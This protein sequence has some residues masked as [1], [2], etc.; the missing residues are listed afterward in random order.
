VGCDH[1]VHVE[2]FSASGYPAVEF[3]TV[4]GGQPFSGLEDPRHAAT[5]RCRRNTRG[6]AWK[7][8]SQTHDHDPEGSLHGLRSLAGAVHDGQGRLDETDSTN[9]SATEWPPLDRRPLLS[10]KEEFYDVIGPVLLQALTKK[11]T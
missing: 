2:P 6:A 10:P 7:T 4:I 1:R 5:W 3:L 9:G 11:L 8:R